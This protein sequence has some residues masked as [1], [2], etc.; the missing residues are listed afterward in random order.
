[1]EL[2][3]L[4]DDDGVRADLAQ[5]ARQCNGH[6]LGKGTDCISA[7]GISNSYPVA[8]SLEGDISLCF[9]IPSN[10][11]HPQAIAVKFSSSP[12]LHLHCVT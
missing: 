6:D 1:M 4:A 3:V 7:S 8:P 5:A 12:A 2:N 9:S 10:R 11:D